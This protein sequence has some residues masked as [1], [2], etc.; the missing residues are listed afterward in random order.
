MVKIKKSNG[1]RYQKRHNFPKIIFNILL[2]SS[3][4]KLSSALKLKYTK[5]TNIPT[6]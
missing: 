6:S 5:E 3:H 1:V 2:M 4:L